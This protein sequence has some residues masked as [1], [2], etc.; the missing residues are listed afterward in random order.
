ME[1]SIGQGE[2]IPE[3]GGHPQVTPPNGGRKQEQTN[4]SANLQITQHP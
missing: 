3:R 1:Q 2:D 4:E